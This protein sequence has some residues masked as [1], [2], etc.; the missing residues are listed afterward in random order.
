MNITPAQDKAAGELVELIASVVGR[1]RA[2]HPETAIS[3]SARLSG[4]LLLR[5]FNL[6]LDPLEPGAILLS[7]EADEKVPLLINIV[8][9][10]L[11]ASHVPLDQQKLGGQPTSRG[12]EPRLDILS[13][14]SLLQEAA[15]KIGKD[16]RLSLEQVAHA[17]ALATA[18]I[19]KEC[20]ARISAETGFNVAA[21]GFI[22]GSKTVP[23]RTAIS[24][25]IPSN[26]KPWYKFW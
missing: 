6:H 1:D 16:N 19:V 25:L 4:S 22:E 21:Y 12:E 10:F 2:I 18:F 23:P 20:A 13:G 17:G 26:A 9:R 14:L 11:S 5:S 24:P 15:M 7:P 8:A 3:A